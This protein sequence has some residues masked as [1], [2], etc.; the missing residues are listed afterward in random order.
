MRKVARFSGTVIRY[1]VDEFIMLINTD[2]LKVMEAYVRRLNSEIATFN[3]ESGKPY[4]IS[5]AIGYCIT[6]LQPE[7]LA[8]AVREADQSMYKDKRGER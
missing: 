6:T 4:E 3:A 2:D 5:V 1:G 7:N 8:E